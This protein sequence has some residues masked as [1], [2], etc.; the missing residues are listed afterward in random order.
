MSTAAPLVEVQDLNVRFVTRESKVRAVNGVSFAMAPGE[1]LCMLGESGSGKSVTM[2][3][4]MRLLPP[5]RAVIDGKVRIAG[6]DVLAMGEGDLRRFRGGT[7]SMIFQEPMTAFDPVARVGDQIAEVVALHKGVSHRQGLARA[8]ELFDL[9]K[10][11][12]AQRRLD[13]YPFELSG[14]LRQRAMIAMA[15]SCEPKLL[16]ADEPTTALDATVQIQVLILLRRLQQEMGMSVIFVTHD[17]GVAA[18]IADRV[19][20]MYAG[21]VVETGPVREVLRDPLHPYTAGLLASTVH[22]QPRDRDLETI[23]GA[24]PDLRNLPPGCKFAPRCSLAAAECLDGEPS[25]RHPAIGRMARC[26]RVPD[27]VLT[28]EFA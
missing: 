6:Q 28:P 1:V 15:L 16:L 19:A 5:K 22:N 4:L 17:L 8:L 24:P 10:I 20:V 9:V 14:G 7:V 25:A 26:V 18:E 13:A 11:P 2:R 21:R 12:S 23:P 3:A 27:A